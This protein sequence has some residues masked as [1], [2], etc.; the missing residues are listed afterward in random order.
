MN[1]SWKKFVGIVT[2]SLKI[3]L[4]TIAHLYGQKIFLILFSLTE[5]QNQSEEVKKKYG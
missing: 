3:E 1:R 2:K 4:G 5:I